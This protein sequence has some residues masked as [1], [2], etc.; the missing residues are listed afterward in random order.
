MIFIGYRSKLKRNSVIVQVSLLSMITLIFC[1]AIKVNAHEKSYLSERMS[2]LSQINVSSDYIRG[3]VMHGDFVN[4]ASLYNDLENELVVMKKYQSLVDTAS[5]QK[6]I[7]SAQQSIIDELCNIIN[8]NTGDYF[9]FDNEFRPKGLIVLGTTPGSGLLKSRLEEAYKI[10]IRND[11]MPII[12]SGKGLR[13]GVVEA[14]YMYDYLLHKGVEAERMYKENNSLDTIGNAEFSY[15]IINEHTRLKGITD[16]LVVTNNFH[17]MRALFNFS[18][19]FPDSYNL[20]VL[21]APLFVAESGK[22]EQSILLRDLIEKEVISDSNRK[23]TDLISYS[24]YNSETD[25]FE[26]ANI[27]GRPCAILS[28]MLIRHPLYRVKT[29]EFAL[30]FSRCFD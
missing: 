25:L 28:E 30:E 22:K 13:Q 17:S 5:A 20:S 7:K 3:S 19:V 2:N 11:S 12:L 27:N 9:P 29:Q 10:A 14:D 26:L 23:F 24:R 8:S 16:W 4:V 6:E 1:F 21:L 18:R 15:F